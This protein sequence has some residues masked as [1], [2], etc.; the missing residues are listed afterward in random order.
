M[1]GAIRNFA[2]FTAPALFGVVVLI[3]PITST[4]LIVSMIALVSVLVAYPLRHLE[5]GLTDQRVE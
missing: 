1:T 4:F 3:L 2:K 5:Q